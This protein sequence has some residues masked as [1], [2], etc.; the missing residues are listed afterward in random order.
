MELNLQIAAKRKVLYTFSVCADFS[1][2]NYNMR[3]PRSISFCSQ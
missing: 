1:A 3:L 2:R